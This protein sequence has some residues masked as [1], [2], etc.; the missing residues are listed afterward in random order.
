M[1]LTLRSVPPPQGFVWLRR[2]F[3]AFMRKPLG[4]TLMFVVFLFAAL[5]A[6]SLPY[7]GGIL[8]MMALPLLTLGFMVA[9]RS[10][11]AGGPVH[12][13]QFVEPLRAAAPNRRALVQLCA[14]Y[15]VT[16]IAIVALSEAVDG[17]AFTRL[18]ELIATQDDTEA[19]RAEL[20]ALLGDDRL[21]WG[22]LVRFGLSALL[23]IPFWYAPALVHW[24]GQGALQSLF[25]STLACW[26]TRGALLSYALGW[27]ALVAVFSVVV[28][29]LFGLLGARQVAGLLA[30]PAGLVF[31]CVFYTS[32]YF[33]FDDT[34]GSAGPPASDP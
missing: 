8:V 20:E 34:F 1:A 15:A 22:L 6:M 4:F 30:L 13:G 23:A 14:F 7:L 21:K 25:S 17:G 26:R 33:T 32:L 29:V 31:T 24:G 11:L 19:T 9:T 5:V 28:G 2:G 3:Q 12:P 10:L 18:Q 27:V 16:T